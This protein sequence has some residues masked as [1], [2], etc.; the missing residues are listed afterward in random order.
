VFVLGVRFG[1]WTAGG[2]DSYGY[3]SQADLWLRGRL[4][5]DQPWVSRFA[6]PEADAVF[7]PLAYRPG[8]TPHTIVPTYPPGL[9]LL[10]AAFGAVGGRG[11]QYLV[12][13]FMGALAVWLTWRLGRK[14]VGETVGLMAALLLASSPA[15]LFHVMQPLSDVPAT[16]A[17]LVAALLVMRATPRPVL[18]GL[19]TAVAIL[20]RPNLAPL[21]L[22]AAAG[23]MLTAADARV[24]RVRRVLLFAA[25]AL[26]GVAAYAAFNAALYGGPLSSGYGSFAE[27][28]TLDDPGGTLLHYLR[29][30]LDT[31]TFLIV[32]APL[33]GLAVGGE[34]EGVSRRRVWLALAGTPVTVLGVY[35]FYVRF[36]EWTY[37]RYLLPAYPA[38]LVL[39][40]A[41]L[42]WIAGGGRA[43]VVAL[44]LPPPLRLLP[45]ALVVAVCL[46]VAA[47]TWR[48]AVTRDLFNI[49]RV[50][51]RYERVAAAVARLTPA[52]AAILCMQHSGTLRYYAS[53]VT[54]RY[55][56]LP[57]DSLH[58]ATSD[59][60]RAG[61]QPF[62]LVEEWELEP[63]RERFP[64]PG[65]DG[66]LDRS[67][68][69]RLWPVP[70]VFLYDAEDSGPSLEP[71]GPR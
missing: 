18:A 67:P 25:G 5:V 21:A 47:A 54:V 69:A 66:P 58:R 9:P 53:R 44:R 13:P 49:R 51:S 33:G 45:S 68:I 42:Q 55:D 38:L 65:P 24:L 12:V 60:R 7:A 6:W 16:T 26:P 23:L 3:V 31:Q 14:A 43:A 22:V 70:A 30:L 52:N 10:M 36:P 11:A 27:V 28:F 17:W 34:R 48:E 8:T 63:F 29:L 50:E 35:A 15:F 59:L 61:Y 56:I 19:A 1:S 37:L 39:S 46:L 20:I 57:P 71:G 62:I 4:H 2:S 32:L 64:G 40:V 41:G